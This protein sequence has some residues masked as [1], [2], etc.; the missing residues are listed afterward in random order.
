MGIFDRFKKQTV[1]TEP[2]KSKSKKKT[3]KELATEKAEAYVNID[4]VQIDAKNPGQGA[5]E[6]DWNEF[7]VAKLVKAGYQG[8]N[9]EQIV[10]QWFQ[11]VCRNVVLETYE[12]YEAN[13]P[14]RV[15]KEDLGGGRSIFG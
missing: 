9:D 13:N 10:D 5:F 7:F 12:Q 11:D 8:K 4:S 6:L 1:Q 14:Q 15:Q 3:A 2:A